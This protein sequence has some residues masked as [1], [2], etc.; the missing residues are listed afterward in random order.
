MPIQSQCD[1]GRPS[2][3]SLKVYLSRL[4]GG[5][6]L[7]GNPVIPIFSSENQV[8]SPKIPGIRHLQ[9]PPASVKGRKSFR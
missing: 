6:G 8:I 3:L 7:S 2:K 9:T 5:E 4:G 1:Y